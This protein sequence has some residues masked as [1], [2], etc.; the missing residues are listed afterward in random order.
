MQAGERIRQ[1]RLE[2]GIRPSQ[3]EQMSRSLARQLQEPRCSISHS[4]LSGIEAGALPSFYKI[5]S[6]A[7]CL[8]LTDDQ[9]LEWYDIDLQTLR[10]TLRQ[11]AV[12]RPVPLYNQPA[13]DLHDGG[14]PFPWPKDAPNFKTELFNDALPGFN[15]SH[16]D[17]F[18]FARIGSKDN[19]MMDMLPPGSFVRVDTGQRK[20]LIFRW[21]SMWHRPI[22]LVW[23]PFGHS[24]RWCQ[25]NG[26]NL[27]LIP[28]PGSHDPVSVFPNPREAAVLG[29]IVS[30][31]I[32]PLESP[33]KLPVSG[34]I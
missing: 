31:W 10:P 6:L 15:S 26:R 14:F 8:R 24:C 32:S 21:E 29:R 33:I 1:R 16:P 19:S 34:F 5:L 18:R 9:I 25:Q 3:V 28:H 4:T 23:H 13:A 20:I 11:R 12:L 17:R 7:F 30:V 22:Y 2:L 27:I